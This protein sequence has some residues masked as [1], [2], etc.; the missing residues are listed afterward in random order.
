MIKNGWKDQLSLVLEGVTMNLI[1]PFYN[2]VKC[3]GG[4][5]AYKGFSL[6]SLK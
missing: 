2:K 4:E 5:L 6:M 1:N 3:Q